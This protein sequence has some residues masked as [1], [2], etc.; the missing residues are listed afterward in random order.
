MG[1]ALTAET[2]YASSVTQSRNAMLVNVYKTAEASP[3]AGPSQVTAEDGGAFTGG[4]CLP[5]THQASFVDG[6]FAAGNVPGHVSIHAGSESI[7]YPLGWGR[8]LG[9]G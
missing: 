8:C 2:K 5:R 3:Q 4:D 9:V 1:P 7:G 6:G